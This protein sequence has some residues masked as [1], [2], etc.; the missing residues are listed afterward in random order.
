M[1]DITYDI[2]V[3]WDNDGV[4]T[5]TGEN[6]T[7]RTLHRGAIK[8]QYGRDQGKAL[9]PIAPGQ[10]AFQV[11]N[12]TKDYS[13]DNS[14]SPLFGNLL[15]GRQV[16][17]TATHNAI[18]YVLL[19]ASIEDYII[20]PKLDARSVTFTAVDGL[21]ELTQRTVSTQLYQTVRTGDA[22]GY[23]LD[24]VGW[25][26][27]RDIDKGATVYPWWWVEGRNGFDAVKDVLAAEGLG[28]IAYIGTSG[29]FVYR[30]RL[31]R[32]TR[33][34]S[35]TSQATFDSSSEPAI[36]KDIAYDV[37]WRDIVNYV[38]CDVTERVQ[39]AALSIIYQDKS[40]RQLAAGETVTINAQSSDP[41]T[42]AV[43]PVSGTDYTV[44]TGTVTVSLSRTSGQSTQVR[45]FANTAAQIEGMSLR[46]RKLTTS[47][48]VT[49]ESRDQDSISKYRTRALK[50]SAPLIG[51]NDAQAIADSII[52]NHKERLPIITIKVVSANDT[53]RVQMLARDLS[54]RVHLTIPEAN[55]DSDFYI[56]R[57]EHL[58]H[59]DFH[60]T[61]FGCEKVL[62][63]IAGVFVLDTSLLD[64]GKV[65]KL[66]F[67]SP[68]ELLILDDTGQ[69]LIG[70]NL[71]GY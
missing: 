13:P 60:E 70:T 46:A 69:G 11:D 7:S 6:V 8:I 65:G 19:L 68:S 64:T 56:E 52:A 63:D 43:T 62:A 9:S 17:M 47:R 55:V 21:G 27:G 49:I 29:E 51:I 38:S 22:I 23:I 41:F 50:Y 1:A 24:A 10:A 66:G 67:I 16:K 71:L 5:G 34:A 32:L 36:D 37:G 15:P 18:D 12:S 25:T 57:I 33:T 39:D 26:A 59:A 35:R 30:D 4:F 45:I 31:H 58:I 2:R 44:R 48:T 53:R 28:A 40:T 42:D 14:S 61:R 20:D 54:D 3:D